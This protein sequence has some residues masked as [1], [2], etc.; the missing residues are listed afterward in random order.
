MERM[1]FSKTETFNSIYQFFARDRDE[2]ILNEI[3]V[4]RD[5]TSGKVDP[6]SVVAKIERTTRKKR[7]NSMYK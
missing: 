3:S 2:S 1:D 7:F 4:V 5:Y 6:S